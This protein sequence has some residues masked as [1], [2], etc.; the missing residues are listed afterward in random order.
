[1][2]KIGAHSLAHNTLGSKGACSNFEMGLGR[3][4]ST[5][6]LTKTCTKATNKLVNAL[7]KHFRC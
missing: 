1:M 2:S 6:S 5:Y 3:M 7:L 4:A